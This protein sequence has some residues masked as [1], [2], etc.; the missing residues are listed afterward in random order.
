MPELDVKGV[1]LDQGGRQLERPGSIP[2]S[3]MARIIG[4]PLRSV[5][6]LTRPLKT[7][8]D[9]GV[10]QPDQFQKGAEFI[11]ET[12]RESPRPVMIATV[13][14]VRDLVAAFNREP[15]LCRGKIGKVM[16]FIGDASSPTFKEYNVELDPQ[17]YVGLMRSGLPVWWVPCFDGGL[18]QN[19]GHA[20]YWKARHADLLKDAAPQVVQYFV[21]ALEHE[22]A[23]PLAFLASPV[24]EERKKRLFAGERNL[25]CTALFAV[26][27]WPPDKTGNELYG[28]PEVE[29]SITDDAVVRYGPS[30]SSHKIRRF[31]V[32]DSVHYAESM[33]AATA[34]WLARL[35]R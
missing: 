10:D 4:R 22:T 7:P 16:A 26:L 6:G 27:A 32:R 2:V 25:W 11:L 23:D 34:A 15:A 5:I 21:Y 20:S 1:V 14:S 35:G 28:F 31:E 30:G 9:S 17:A 18:W 8:T 29:V 33:T 13:G 19:Q 24:N 12:L 3:Q